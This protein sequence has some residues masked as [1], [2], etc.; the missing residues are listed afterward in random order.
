MLQYRKPN[1]NHNTIYDNI[2]I[3]SYA[4]T[5]GEVPIY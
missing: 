5:A 2:I 1:P 4:H 3:K